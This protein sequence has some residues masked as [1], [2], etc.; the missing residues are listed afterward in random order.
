VPNQTGYGYDYGIKASFFDEKL[1]FT[2]GGYYIVRENVTVD[3][4]D[5]DTGL[6]IKRAEGTQLY[7]GEE[8]DGNWRV[9]EDFTIGGNVGHSDAR[10]VNLGY[11]YMSIGRSPSNATPLN[12]GFY[13]KYVFRHALKGLSANLGVVY[14]G[15]TPTEA[16]DAGDTYNTGSGKDGKFVSSTGQWAIKVPGWTVWN[17]GIRYNLRTDWLTKFSHTIAL[18]VNNLFDKRYLNGRG[19]GENRSFYA[20]YT[21]SH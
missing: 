14:R 15:P 5:P 6:T 17:L 8:F 19:L 11:K 18:N 13:S 9:T 21:L 16:P 7:R 3:D 1:N 4:L 2:L 10:T 12:V 20:T